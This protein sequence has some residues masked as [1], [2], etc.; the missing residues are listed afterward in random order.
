MGFVA[1]GHN[2][3]DY[4]ISHRWDTE[5][6]QPAAAPAPTTQFNAESSDS[7]G[8]MGRITSMVSDIITKAK[9]GKTKETLMIGVGII[10]LVLVVRGYLADQSE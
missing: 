9:T 6:V 3:Q 2:Y 1:E 10:G 4:M 7:G 8:I 5:E